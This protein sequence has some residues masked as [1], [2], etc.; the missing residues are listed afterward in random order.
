MGF[1]GL[2]AAALGALAIVAGGAHALADHRDLLGVWVGHSDIDDF[3][4]ETVEGRIEYTSRPTDFAFETF[5]GGVGPLAGLMVNGKGSVF[6][7][8][9][10]YGDFFV[11]G[12]FVIRPEVGLGAFKPG[13]AKDLGGVFEI[14]AALGVAYVFD[15]EARLGVTATHISNTGVHDSNPGLDSLLLSYSIPIGP[16]F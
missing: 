8:A 6:A 3:D 2:L 11:G 16:L 9:G 13:D 10:I 1:R 7:Y 15:N 4:E 5:F 14:H 12:R